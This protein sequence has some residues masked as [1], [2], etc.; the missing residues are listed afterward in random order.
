M[1][2]TKKASQGSSGKDDTEQIVLDYLKKQNRP[3]SAT[4]ISSNLHNAVTKTATQ[5]ILSSLVTQDEVTCKT[6]GK[7]TVYVIKQDQFES[8][9]NDELV[10]MD[11]QIEAIKNEINQY[12]EETKQ[13]QSVL[14]GLNNSLT[15]EQIETELN[16]LNEENAKYEERL[17]E[18]R[19]GTRLISRE[20]KENID[21][22]YERNRKLWKE[23]KRMCM[24]ILDPMC[25]SM[26]KKPA[27][28]M[29]ELGLESDPVNFNV[30][31]LTNVSIVRLRKGGKRFEVACYKNKV[32]EWRNGIETDLDN[33]LQINNVFLNVS[34]GQVAPKDDLQKAFKTE[35]LNKII[36]EILKKGEMQVGEKERSNQIDNTY[37]EI[38]TMVAEKCVNPETKRPYTVTMIE[39][40]MGELHISVKT[41]RSTKSQALDVI[42]QIQE[43]KIIPIARAQ[44]RLRITIPNVK[45]GKRIREK[46]VPLIAQTEDENFDGDEYELLCTIDPGQYRA[47]SE[48]LQNDTKGK[49]QL[50]LLSLNDTSEGDIQL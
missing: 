10:Q 27:E 43:K 19:S 31:P 9:S 7:Q 12:K 50:E 3:Y 28:V 39:K 40:A 13:L 33:V 25:E 42:K 30:D 29:E 24:D 4:D 6:Y 32:L 38:A 5:K 11:S 21:M 2:K 22:M 26:E 47:I 49:G 23:R 20:E 41:N 48:L 15:N 34:K 37:R 17:K 14:S 46:L 1:A 8:P 16:S 35:D 18:L 44:M 36:E 45:E